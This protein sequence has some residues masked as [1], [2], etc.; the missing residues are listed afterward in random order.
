MTTVT[1]QQ[2]VANYMGALAHL[3][4]GRPGRHAEFI[5]KVELIVSGAEPH[6]LQLM[7]FTDRC[8]ATGRPVLWVHVAPDVPTV[9]RI[10]LVVSVDGQARIFEQCMLWIG[11]EGGR[12]RLVPDGFDWGAYRFDDE[13]RLQ[14]IAEAPARSFEG[15]KSGMIR[16]YRRLIRLE[17][18]Q[19]RKGG[20]LPLPQLARAA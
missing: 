1:D 2:R 13:L 8:R 18:E 15:A 9:P 17:V 10:G 20:A 3:L 7:Q 19:I 11:T 6:A 14:H 12:A 4:G 16:A 5:Q